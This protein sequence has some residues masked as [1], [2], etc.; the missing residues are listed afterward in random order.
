[1]ARIFTLTPE[2]VR[3]LGYIVNN[4]QKTGWKDRVADILQ[5]APRTVESWAKGDR[6][7]NGPSALL[8][9][10]YSKAIHDGTYEKPSLDEVRLLVEKHGKRID[11]D[12]GSVDVRRKIR[13]AVRMTS[14]IR[15][16]SAEL[17]LNRTALSRWFS[18]DSALGFDSVAALL[19]HLGLDRKDDREITRRWTVKN[20]GGPDVG[21]R[22]DLHDA[23][24]IMFPEPPDCRL[25]QLGP[26]K[27]RMVTVA[28][29]LTRE[30]VRVVLLICV[31]E[32][33]FLD[34]ALEWITGLFS[35]LRTPPASCVAGGS[36]DAVEETGLAADRLGD[37]GETGVAGATLDS[38]GESI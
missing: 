35:G 25:V 26:P 23:I 31:R 27:D 14:S 22:R 30:E 28:A 38:E 33:F 12:I 4:N 7:C 21:V 16:V 32:T 1:M 13:A 17:D 34:G 9:W 24:D 36:I 6:I 8:L 5:V 29:F 18:G 11:L 37:A 10:H 2:L 19:A 20:L 15:H 3:A